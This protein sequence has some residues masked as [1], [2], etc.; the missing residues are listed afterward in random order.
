[1]PKKR[2]SDGKGNVHPMDMPDRYASRC[3]ICNETIRA[4]TKK[5]LKTAQL[6]HLLMAH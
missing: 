5:D 2:R 4:A 3:K 6:A 1:M